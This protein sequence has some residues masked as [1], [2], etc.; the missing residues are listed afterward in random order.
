MTSVD[1]MRTP[2]VSLRS[3]SSPSFEGRQVFQ[4]ARLRAEARPQDEAGGD[5]AND[6]TVGRNV[7][8]VEAVI[9]L[10]QCVSC[11]PSVTVRHSL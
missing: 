8:Y 5:A 10:S 4:F 9:V 3:T 11:P 1:K 2:S 6:Y 7:C